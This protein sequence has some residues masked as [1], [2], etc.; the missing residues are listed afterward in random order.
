MR[1]AVG[2]YWTLP[3][4]WAGFAALP[5]DVDDAAKASRTI[6]YQCELIRRHAKDEGL[7]LIAEEVFLE[8]APDRGSTHA[9]EA[10]RK[11]ERLCREGAAVLLLVDFAAVQGWRGHGPLSEWSRRT[12]IE[13]R[14]VYPDAIAIDGARF[15]PH[16]HFAEWRARQAEW[17][18]GK[19]ERSRLALAEA[20]RLCAEGRTNASIAASLNAGHVRS[21]TGRPWTGEGIRKLLKPAP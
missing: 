17:M 9:A 8:L 13:V 3:V 18:R 19:A 5:A 1:D 7:R 12:R 14:P 2:F 10:L 6:R 20:R 15:D 21:A 4:P 16:A 11:V